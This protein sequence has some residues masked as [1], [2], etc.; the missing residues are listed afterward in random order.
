VPGLSSLAVW[1]SCRYCAVSWSLRNLRYLDLVEAIIADRLSP[2]EAPVASDEED[3]G[4]ALQMVQWVRNR[5]NAR[6]V[7]EFVAEWRAAEAA[8]NA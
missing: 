2:H 6:D 3:L 1:R 7:A 5:A 4:C 8:K